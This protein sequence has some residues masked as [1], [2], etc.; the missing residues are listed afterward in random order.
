[1]PA[2]ST[3]IEPA[4][5]CVLCRHPLQAIVIETFVR[6]HEEA[7]AERLPEPL[8]DASQ[9]SN[10]QF[11][12][13]DG[14]TLDGVQ[15]LDYDDDNDD[16]HDD[17]DDGDNGVNY[18]PGDITESRQPA[19][20]VAVAPPFAHRSLSLDDAG[21]ASDGAAPSDDA[22]GASM[23]A[24]ARTLPQNRHRRPPPGPL[25]IPTALHS[26]FRTA[27]TAASSPP[28]S[29]PRASD[30]GAM[31][32]RERELIFRALGRNA[33]HWERAVLGEV[34]MSVC[35]MCVCLCSPYLTPPRV[36]VA[37]HTQKVEFDS[38][39]RKIQAKR[40]LKHAMKVREDGMQPHLYSPAL[41]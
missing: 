6:T 19:G 11:G 20:G 24:S 39:F 15:F 28:A 1:M 34:C 17:D 13:D 4:H 10:E 3:L 26:S 29:K 16:D 21:V 8:L 31:T 14:A 2:R 22:G 37:G 38:V 5:P 12:F 33:A 35:C 18:E 7:A 27:S 41:I 23:F 36:M 30:S 32:A 9:R 25:P 40:R